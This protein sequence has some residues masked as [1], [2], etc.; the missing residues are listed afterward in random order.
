[1]GPEGG[2]LSVA[3]ITLSLRDSTSFA[4]FLSRS[5]AI[6]RASSGEG[7]NDKGWGL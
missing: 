5:V 1:M 3:I 6:L 2:A 7:V 4:V